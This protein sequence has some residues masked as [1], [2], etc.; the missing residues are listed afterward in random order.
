MD[1]GSAQMLYADFIHRE[2]SGSK[3]SFVLTI[4][5]LI[6]IV[7]YFIWHAIKQK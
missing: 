1:T 2:N 3:P 6:I 4:L 5:T 7:I